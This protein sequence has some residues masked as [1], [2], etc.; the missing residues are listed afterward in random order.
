LVDTFANVREER[1]RCRMVQ[2]R[3][4]EEAVALLTREPNSVLH[5]SYQV[6]LAAAVRQEISA[7][8]ERSVD[9]RKAAELRELLGR[10]TT[11]VG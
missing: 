8:L 5:R 1:K 3:R 11:R 2:G 7:T 9:H 6:E 10:T 4:S